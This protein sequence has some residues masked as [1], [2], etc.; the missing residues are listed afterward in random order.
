MAADDVRVLACAVCETVEEIPPYDGPPEQDE[1]LTY[2]VQ[3]HKFDSGTP[4]IGQLFRVAEKDWN[5]ISKRDQILKQ[6]KARLDPD[7]ETG[8]G[9]EAYAMVDN[10]KADA[11]ECFNQHFRNPAC[12]DYKTEH[13]RLVPAT[14]NERRELGLSPVAQYDREGGGVTRYLCE[15]CPVH[16]LVEQA[17]RKKAGLYDK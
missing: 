10:F 7:A 14:A 15:Y 8:L 2:A 6:I 1:T 4:H 3:K 16:S 9:S 13:K 11:M 5:V 17:A 12:N